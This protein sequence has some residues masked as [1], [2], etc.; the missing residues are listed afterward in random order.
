MKRYLLILF[1]TLLSLTLSAVPARRLHKKDFERPARAI[2]HMPERV[3]VGTL[4]LPPAVPVIL[5]EFS[6][7]GFQKQN[8]A[9]AFDSLFNSDN[10]TYNGATGSVRQYFADQSYGKYLPRFDIIGK[11]KLSK[12]VTY[13]GQNKGNIDGQDIHAGE[14]IAEA[15]L[16]A[17][18]IYDIDFSQYDSDGDG[19]V[20]AV[21]VVYAGYGEADGGAEYTIWPHNWTISAAGGTTPTIDGKKVSVYVCSGEIY[22]EYWDRNI[23]LREGIGIICH[24]FSHVLGLPDA[25]TT[26]GASHKT[27]GD[28]DIMDM[29]AY[30]NDSRTPPA[31]SSYERFFMGWTT[32]AILN[33]ANT[34]D[35]Q[36]INSEGE[37]YLIS[38]D[39]K[40]NL[41][42]VSPSPTEF[43]LLENRQRQGW[44]K[45]IPGDG[46]MITKIIYNSTLWSSNKVNNTRSSMGIDLIEADSSAPAY[47]GEEN[48]HYGKATDLFPAGSSAF[49]PYEQYPI[50][51]IE[52]TNGIVRF[53]FM[54]G[55]AIAPDTTFTV[56][57]DTENAV[58]I[59]ADT[60]KAGEN[61]I[62]TLIAD[63][64][65]YIDDVAITMGFTDLI[66]DEDYT[67]ENGVLTVFNVQDELYILVIAT[68]ETTTRLTDQLSIG[69]TINQQQ[70][71][72]IS[73]NTEKRIVVYNQIGQ[74]I[75]SS[76]FINKYQVYLAQGLYFAI[77]T[78]Q[79][80][81]QLTKT[82]I[83]K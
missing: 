26:N 83:L 37:C 53:R 40:H 34:I 75:N 13:Y 6:D 27:L 22:L 14:M 1:S 78:D 67:L 7:L 25:Y 70:V 82:I 59:G 64:G 11:V 33:E 56:T 41:N 54:G 81:Q 57:L 43:Y 60:A 44:D 39:G 55:K 79:N 50:T 2:C 45:Y 32:P 68:K 52:M 31:Y 65:Y 19:R 35:M 24:E 71:T 9:I 72:I 47:I 49:T 38:A 62:A 46:M 61:Y 10:Y 69:I 80:G 77:I 66:E 16:I 23:D 20:D 29:G 36:N 42:G 48:G 63:K 18:T 28:W 51:D 5:A 4:N 74:L 17:D 21:Y 15:C 30:N 76:T 8:D 3:Q 12:S 58:A 73:D